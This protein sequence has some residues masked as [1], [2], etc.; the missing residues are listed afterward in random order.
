MKN[1]KIVA[2][3]AGVRTKELRIYLDDIVAFQA[4]S[5]YTMAKLSNGSELFVRGLAGERQPA[6]TGEYTLA[7]LHDW[8][9]ANN[10]KEF[11]RTH[12]SCIVNLRQVREWLPRQQGDTCTKLLAADQREYPISRR[13]L[14][15]IRKAWRAGIVASATAL[16]LAIAIA[17]PYPADAADFHLATEYPETA[18]CAAVRAEL[19][20]N[21]W[22][23]RIACDCEPRA[24]YCMSW[25]DEGMILEA[26]RPQDLPANATGLLGV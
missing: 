11:M 3:G 13:W 14:P 24:E 22:A 19:E 18:A 9:V 20:N 7:E 4:D 5:K 26:L 25:D 1:L 15:K 23:E 2:K 21:P 16:M 10:C 8:L 6:H 17:L 12:R